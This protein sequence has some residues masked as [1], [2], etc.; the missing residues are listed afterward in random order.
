MGKKVIVVGAGLEGLSAACLLA[1][2]GYDVTALEKNSDAGCT[3]I[4]AGGILKDN[5]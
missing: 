5:S 2:K 1:S 3:R 4:T